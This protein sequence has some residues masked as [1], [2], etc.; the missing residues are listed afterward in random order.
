MSNRVITL[1]LVATALE[2]FKGKPIDLTVIA[3]IV[4]DVDRLRKV[5]TFVPTPEATSVAGVFAGAEGEAAA[6]TG[7]ADEKLAGDQDAPAPETDAG[8]ARPPKPK[9][10]TFLAVLDPEGKLKGIELMGWALQTPI[11]DPAD[12]TGVIARVMRA[13]NSHNDS[14]R[15]RKDP[16]STI[17]EAFERMPNKFWRM[18]SSKRV[19]ETRVILVGLPAELPK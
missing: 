11:S 15:G 7:P 19:N 14:K 8:N 9:L 17:P 4:A 18:A 1:E 5:E 3:A 16:V 10:Q 13:V 12:G 2:N 6:E